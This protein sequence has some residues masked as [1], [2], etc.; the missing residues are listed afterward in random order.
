[1][2]RLL[3]NSLILNEQQLA[4]NFSAGYI[5]YLVLLQQF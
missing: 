5:L 4:A 3:E 2:Y 1:M